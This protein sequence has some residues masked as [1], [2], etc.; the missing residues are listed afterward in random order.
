MTSDKG[1]FA[2]RLYFPRVGKERREKR[3][4]E[5]KWTSG[6]LQRQAGAL[7]PPVLTSS[8]LAPAGLFLSHHSQDFKGDLGP[9][10]LEGAAVISELQPEGTLRELSGDHL[11]S[12][13]RKVSSQRQLGISGGKGALFLTAV[14][15]EMVAYGRRKARGLSRAQQTPSLLRLLAAARH[16]DS[17]VCCLF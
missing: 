16:T 3:V 9:S 10:K 1:C 5:W 13:I 7:T 8:G 17:P 6:A 2:F 12:P 14:Q 4:P 11:V 15:E